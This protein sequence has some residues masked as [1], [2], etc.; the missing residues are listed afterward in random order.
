MKA[1]GDPD[2]YVPAFDYNMY[3]YSREDAPI[4][5]TDRPSTSKYLH[6]LD[7]DSKTGTVYFGNNYFGY[8]SFGPYVY[9]NSSYNK[10]FRGMPITKQVIL[11]EQNRCTA[12][13]R[14]YLNNN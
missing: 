3:Y 4:Y 2:L 8:I 14:V 12:E 13:M 6:A 9:D 11:L 7:V 10:Y 1:F 5:F